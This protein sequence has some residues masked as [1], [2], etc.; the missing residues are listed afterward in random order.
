MKASSQI[1][2]GMAAV[3]FLTWFGSIGRVAAYP[4]DPDNAALLYY[5]AFLLCPQTDDRAMMDKVFEVASGR[6]APDDQ[7]K[8]Y[9]KSCRDAIDCAVAATQL[10][11][12][13]WGLRYSKGFSIA[14]PQLAQIRSLTWRVLADARIL[15]AQGDYR[16]ALE[17]CL[18]VYR[19]AGHVGD[20][21]LISFLVSVAVS[22]QA[23]KCVTAILEQ[24]PADADAL[25]WLKGQLAAAPVAKLT[26]VR[27]MTLEEEISSEYLQP[28][29]VAEL[30]AILAEP[31][32]MSAEEIRKLIS[33][34]VLERAR[35]YYASYRDSA[36][37]ILGG[38]TPYAESY[39]K[40]QEL[41]NQMEQAAAK[42]PAVRLIKA[43][44]PAMTKIY[45]AQT[46]FKADFNAL[47]AALDVYIAKAATGQLPQS[48]PGAS[49]RDPYTG[50]AFKY[51]RTNDGF[52]LRC[53]INDADKNEARQFKFQVK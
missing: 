50:D 6:V 21:V 42:D 33:E 24:M 12:C 40:L 30:P 47:Q 13:D 48:L 10:Q 45:V 35:A 39:P 53:G 38:Q 18:T 25:T 20:E 11:R 43:I 2:L 49:P 1:K 3:V 29:R 4:P 31:S 26:A 9:V 41:A 46:R 17:R 14:F 22:T 27:A 34:P 8:E 52:V 51:E 16:Q 32:G 5:Q 37:P 36:L 23:N 19:M 15:A 28:K 7:V 44:A